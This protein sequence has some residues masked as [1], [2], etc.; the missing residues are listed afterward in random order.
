MNI[1]Q[2][3]IYLVVIILTILVLAY[4]SS[5]SE[6]NSSF[7][8]FTNKLAILNGIFIGFGII[9]TFFIFNSNLEQH[10]KDITL[11]I[12]FYSWVDI[13]K[14][15]N[16]CYKDCPN[17]V[18]TLYFDWQKNATQSDLFIKDLSQ[19]NDIKKQ[20]DKWS[21]VTYICSMI[22]QSWENYLTSSEVD[23][24]DEITWISI[25]TQWSYSPIV[26]KVWNETKSAYTILTIRFGNLLT[27]NAE[28]SPKPS[29]F[30]DLINTAKKL[31]KSEKYKD[32]VI[33]RKTDF[34]L[35]EDHV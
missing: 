13:N 34:N 25:F 7:D 29:N 10:R 8:R 16:D 1:N 26:R 5:Q 32:I 30:Q 31:I 23:E 6:I 19:E 12:V 24:T 17:F 9:L 33:K 20:K 11:K 2:I 28:H 3:I 35:T 21:A 27:S 4:F 15:I 14:A 22:F 18:E